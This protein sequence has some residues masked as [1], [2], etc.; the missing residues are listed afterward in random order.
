MIYTGMNKLG[1]Q[2]I[3][4][5]AVGRGCVRTLRASANMLKQEI[6]KTCQEHFTAGRELS[7]HAQTIADS[8]EQLEK[9]RSKVIE[10]RQSNCGSHSMFCLAEFFCI[11][12]FEIKVVCFVHSVSAHTCSHTRTH[13]RTHTKYKQ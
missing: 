8:I 10:R 13:T 6:D 9:S 7:E 4:A 5:S 11:Y 1:N 3:A 12:S 2:S